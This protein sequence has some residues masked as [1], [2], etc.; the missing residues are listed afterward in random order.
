MMKRSTVILAN[1]ATA[2]AL[3]ASLPAAANEQLAQKYGCL[4][5][6]QVDKKLVGPAYKDVAAK[7]RADKGAEARLVDKVKKGGVGVWG[8]IMMPP[9]PSVPDADLHALVKWILSR[10]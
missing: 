2:A 8:Q 5:C 4:A 7:Y 10:K 3:A 9:N 1:V 6:H